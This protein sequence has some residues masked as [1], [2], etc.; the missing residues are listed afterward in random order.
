MALIAVA[1]DKG[2][3]GVTTTSVALA[4]VW[5]R[6]VLL[7]ECDAAGGDLV[8]RLPS[9]DGTRLDPRRGLLSLAVSARRGLEPRQVWEHAQKL[10]GGLD[11]LVGVT[12]AEQGAG[13]DPLWGQVGAAL[14]GLPDA[15]VIADCGRVGSEGRYYDLL[16]RADAVVM[17]TRA[18]LG[19]MVRIR[20]R[21]SV[22]DAAVR[23]RTGAGRVSVLVIA[24]YKSFSAA[25]GEVKQVLSS[26]DWPAPI[27][28]GI[29]YEPRSAE[30][31]S[32]E[33]GGKLDKSLLIRT[34][35]EVAGDLSGQLPGGPAAPRQAAAARPAAG[36][37]PAPA[38]HAAVVQPAPARPPV[39]HP[40][41]AGPPASVL[42]PLPAPASDPLAVPTAPEPRPE[43]SAWPSAAEHWPQQRS[44]TPLPP[45]QLPA[46]GHPAA[47][48]APAPVSPLHRPAPSPPTLPYQ[49]PAAAPV[50]PA[51]AEPSAL[52]AA[53]L[54]PRQPQVPQPPQP[55]QPQPPGPQQSGAHQ[56]GGRTPARPAPL[57]AVPQL[58][59]PTTGSQPRTGPQQAVPQ[60][61]VPQ[62]PVPRQFGSEQL[63]SGQSEAGRFE[64]EPFGWPSQQHPAQPPAGRRELDPPH[65]E[66]PFPPR[67]DYPERT[68][69]P[70]R[71]DYPEGG[72]Y[73]A[74]RD[75]PRDDEYPA[76]P[77]QP[78]HSDE[79]IPGL[80][81]GQPATDGG[82]G[83]GRGRHAGGSSGQVTAEPGRR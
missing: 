16:A 36:A 61:P 34:A 63:G 6:P 60:Q 83:A 25:L 23:R 81:R 48:P 44:L 56:P 47:E 79:L 75:Y 72:S 58:P 43:A 65:R 73:S 4:A 52:P 74:R 28:G 38:V 13:L 69:Y 64:A 51:E 12:N 49:R 82:R 50:A 2:A 30:L 68:S 62:Q 35:R 39:A 20:D 66:Q 17:I 8:Y 21:V 67:A 76:Q 78:E 5:P 33:W 22:V 42:P 11:V 40:A 53:R 54:A 32:G 59:G 26:G 31:L 14:A 9:A 19:D 80:R 77:E 18:S 27:L 46:P 41:P 55:L 3:P 70:E 1:A 29:A 45:G 15:D 71:T 7:A 57:R 24:N 10:R 37:H